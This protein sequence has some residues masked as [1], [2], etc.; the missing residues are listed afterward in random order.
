MGKSAVYAKGESC[1]RTWGERSANAPT[2]VAYTPSV[3]GMVAPAV[4]WNTSSSLMGVP[5]S[6]DQV[7][8]LIG[9]EA[10]P[11]VQNF[12]SQESIINWVNSV[13]ALWMDDGGN[14]GVQATYTELS[15][16]WSP[17]NCEPPLGVHWF[18][19]ETA[20]SAT[21]IRKIEAESLAGLIQSIVSRPWQIRDEQTQELRP[22]KYADVCILLPT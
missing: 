4:S 15:P 12:R 7:R 9:G 18:G 22:A 19:G 2:I 14:P 6:L 17:P 11:L 10:V 1:S 21:H 16:S 20:G 13:F 5:A 8:G 3:R